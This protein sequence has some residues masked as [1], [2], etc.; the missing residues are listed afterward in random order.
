MKWLNN[1]KVGKKLALLIGLA[2]A[3]LALISGLSYYF[4][5]KTNQNLKEMYQE[6]LLSVEYLDEARIQAT[7]ARENIF[8]LMCTSDA[9]ENAQ[10]LKEINNY[11]VVFNSYITKYENL[12]KDDYETGKI[13][14][15]QSNLTQYRSGR[16][17]V[18]DLTKQNKN[19]EAYAGFEK[20]VEKYA[21]GF[22]TDL[23]DLGKH[24]SERAQTIYLQS[25]MSYKSVV[26]L[27]VVVLIFT[28]L[29]ISFLGVMI[30]RRIIKRLGDVVSF[31][32]IL[33]EGDFSSPV[34]EDNLEDKSEFGTVSI[35]IEK[36]RQS[37]QTLMEKIDDT[38]LQLSI[39]AE[40]LKE[41]SEQTVEAS[42]QIASSVS[43]MAEGAN[44]QSTMSSDTNDAVQNI[45]HGIDQVYGNTK[46]VTAL[47]GQTEMTVNEGQSAVRQVRGQMQ[48]VDKKT[49]ET[50][51][52]IRELNEKSVEI[53]SVIG[54]IN[55]MSEQTNLLSLNASIEAARAGTA[56]RGFAVVASEI[57]KL[58]EQSQTATN[59]I[60]DIV[61]EILKSTQNAVMFMEQSSKEVTSGV[62]MVEQAEESFNGIYQVVGK[63]IREIETVSGKIYEMTDD[64]HSSAEKVGKIKKISIS[65]SDDSQSIS[66]A[67]QEQLSAMEEIASSCNML[68]N[69]AGDLKK[70][71]HHFKFRK[72]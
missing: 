70:L 32:G 69:M 41:S 1:L 27:F 67:T 33:A 5:T 61:K 34:G 22:I 43:T 50:S 53:G 72:E 36:M 51:E 3:G 13:K 6:R 20:N 16:I 63:I 37:V 8:R 58:A 19:K 26:S 44:E 24:N 71:I 12:P 21:D 48:V 56:G 42:N 46:T 66:A 28:A 65:I 29:F 10:Y 68:S 31:M 60:A 55:E 7:S 38:A 9:K 2:L 62:S 11:V 54:V 4:L 35:S 25:E 40:Q 47:T 23:V 59:E 52:I 17:A 57:G 30:I 64:I 18:L 45:S 49:E 39:S 15:M 14:D